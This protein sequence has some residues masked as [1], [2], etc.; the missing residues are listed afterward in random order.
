MYIVC[1]FFGLVDK[2]VHPI[3]SCYI[4]YLLF[5]YLFIYL[6]ILMGH[7]AMDEIFLNKIVVRFNCILFGS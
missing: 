6:F 1:L 2:V 5:I 7:R 3:I 4:W